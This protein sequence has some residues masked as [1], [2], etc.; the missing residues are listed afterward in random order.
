MAEVAAQ[1]RRVL[2]VA[3][4][5]AL[6]GAATVVEVAHLAATAD[7][8]SAASEAWEWASQ[9]KPIQT[10]FTALAGGYACKV[11]LQIVLAEAGSA[12]S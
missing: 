4:S 3:A 7:D 9:A 10:V 11:G 6:V 12:L 1:R 2:P 5:I 8:R